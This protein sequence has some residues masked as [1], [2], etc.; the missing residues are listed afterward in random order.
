MVRFSY[1]KGL[2]FIES[3]TKRAWTI[4]RQLPTGKFQLEDD[5]GEIKT[6]TQSELNILHAKEN[7]VVDE[8]SLGSAANV[9]Y[10]AT[11]RDLSTFTEHSQK[12]AKRCKKYIDEIR[13]IF[14]EKGEEL[15]FSPDKLKSV[16]F[17]ASQ[18][19]ND[20]KAPPGASTVYRWFSKFHKTKS[21]IKLVDKR[22]EASGRKSDPVIKSIF[23]ESVN[24]VYLSA[25]KLPKKD[26]WD[27]VCSKVSRINQGVDPDEQIKEPGRATIYRWLNEL[28]AFLVE[29]ARE[30]KSAAQKKFREVLDSI[31]VTRILERIEI[32][33]SPLDVLVIDVLTKMPLGRPWITLAIDRYSR[34]ILGFYI[35]F[36]AP[37]ARAVLYCFRQAVLPKD[38]ILERYPEIKNIWPCYGLP[39]LAVFDNGL[40]AHADDVESV[41][42]EVGTPILYCGVAN[43]EM[44]GA[45]ERAF[46]TLE[47]GLIHRLPG[48]VFNCVDERGD[49]PSEDVACIDLATLT[50]LVV[51]WIVN[52]YLRSP[53][54]GLNG[55]KP[56]EVW[57]ESAKSTI[58]E[59][60]AYPDQLRVL[61]G[62]TTTRALFHYGIELDCL[63][64]NSVQLMAI[65]DRESKNQRVTI[66]YYD[67][68]IS[69]VDVFDNETKEYIRI[70]AVDQQYA[71]GL[72]R[73][74]HLIARRIAAKRFGDQW[75][76]SELREAKEE[77]NEIIARAL[78]DKKMGTRKAA[79][80]V[81]V[82]DSE[83]VLSGE[84]S[85][86]NKARQPKK[87]SKKSTEPLPSGLDDDLPDYIS[88]RI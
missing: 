61:V 78:D 25:Q 22:G 41:F 84:E 27:R 52:I 45:I 38:H 31:R 18:N 59:L 16:I 46:L 3:C 75:T 37:S 54:K 40:D 34:A 55:L 87:A 12:H 67:D 68:D 72:T 53:H 20:G 65:R 1:R 47:E 63:K 39:E 73:H 7:W 83:Q 4:I 17:Q 56:V 30:G 28:H 5:Q 58:F 50:E 9:I 43:P 48:T 15:V 57:L 19:I 21:I 44:K 71:K 10:H 86:L 13:R 42:E 60:P 2:R 62:S 80:R 70:P 14:V 29:S 33:H 69:F 24:E 82:H 66:R 88:E 49:Y 79:A 26:V 74:A 8:D 81:L 51:K 23:D 35:S 36:R 64:Y 76:Q 77:I 11:P 32:D 6:H 85:P